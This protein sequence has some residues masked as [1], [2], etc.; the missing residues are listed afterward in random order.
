MKVTILFKDQTNITFCNAIESYIFEKNFL[1]ITYSEEDNKSCTAIFNIDEIIGYI[2]E[3][4]KSNGNSNN[5][6]Y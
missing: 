6:R 4:E 2:V 1:K 5:Q 3:K